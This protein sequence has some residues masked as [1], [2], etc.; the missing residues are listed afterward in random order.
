MVTGSYARRYAQAIFELD[1]KEHLAEWQSDL[2]TILALGQDATV[3][4]YLEN[5]KIH[6]EDKAKILKERL[7]GIHPLLLNLIYVLL[8][9]SR[10]DMLPAIAAEYQHLV[11]EYQGVER[12]DVTSAVP[13]DDEAKQGLSQRLGKILGKKVIV[14]TERVDPSLI[15]GIIVRIAGKLLDGST[16]SK[17]DTLKKEIAKK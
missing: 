17:L 2:E 5:P 16:R 4:A 9:R 6:F 10:L 13:L 15:G 3:A 7:G 14:E 11:D 8:T 12:A 1:E